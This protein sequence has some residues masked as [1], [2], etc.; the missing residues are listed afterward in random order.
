M[1]KIKLEDPI[2]EKTEHDM[3][4]EKLTLIQEVIKPIDELYTEAA[5]GIAKLDAAISMAG[6]GSFTIPSSWVG[7]DG[8]WTNTRLA[9]IAHGFKARAMVSV[10]ICCSRADK[11]LAAI[12]AMPS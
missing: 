11:V 7:D 9:Q 5:A 12:W 8:T 2:N 6:Q 1:K 4:A 3:T 10:A